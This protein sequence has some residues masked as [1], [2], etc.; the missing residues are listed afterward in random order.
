[1]IERKG[2]SAAEMWLPRAARAAAATGSFY[3]R[4]SGLRQNGKSGVHIR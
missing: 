1:M 4:H 2:A 3:L